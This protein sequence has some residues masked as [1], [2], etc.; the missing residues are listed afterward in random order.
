MEKQLVLNKYE[1]GV[2]QTFLMFNYYIEQ[3]R[4][5]DPGILVATREGSEGIELK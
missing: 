3:C 5:H 4:R 1:I 2:I